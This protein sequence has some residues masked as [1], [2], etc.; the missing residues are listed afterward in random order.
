MG[1]EGIDRAT[2]IKHPIGL[3]L[4]GLGTSGYG[5]IEPGPYTRLVQPTAVRGVQLPASRA[6]D[7]GDDAEALGAC[8]ELQL[9]DLAL[10]AVRL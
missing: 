5:R 2:L 6:V 10:V 3:I 7:V 9:D 8:G 4:S 1:S